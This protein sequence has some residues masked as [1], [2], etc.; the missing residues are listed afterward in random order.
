MKPIPPD[1]GL[2]FEPPAGWLGMFC[3]A[4]G[5]EMT[6]LTVE[7]ALAPLESVTVSVTV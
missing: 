2:K 5:G 6:T 7:K 3:G 1:A 4:A